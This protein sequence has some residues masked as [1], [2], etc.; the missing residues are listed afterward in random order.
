MMQKKDL[1]KK[2]TAALL[3]SGGSVDQKITSATRLRIQDARSW[4]EVI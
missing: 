2:L 3:E 4:N 1:E